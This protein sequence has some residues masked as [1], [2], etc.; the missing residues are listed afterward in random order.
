M[1]NVVQLNFFNFGK[2]LETLKEKSEEKLEQL[3]AENFNRL[4]FIDEL[5]QNVRF[6]KSVIYIG[7]NRRWFAKQAASELKQFDDEK[8]LEK[9]KYYIKQNFNINFELDAD[10]DSCFLILRM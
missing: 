9:L 2:E 5:K 10:S 3:I 1:T 7:K 6:L 8:F 4:E